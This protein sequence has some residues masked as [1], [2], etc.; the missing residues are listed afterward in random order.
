MK[1]TAMDIGR[2]GGEGPCGWI[3]G[4]GDRR[5][6]LKPL[7]ARS[8]VGP[9]PDPGRNG[10]M[11]QP[12]IFFS[13]DEIK[14]FNVFQIN[15]NGDGI[16]RAVNVP[17]SRCPLV[18]LF[19][20]GALAEGSGIG[21]ARAVELELAWILSSIPLQPRPMRLQSHLDNGHFTTGRCASCYRL[22]WTA[23]GTGV[24]FHLTCFIP[25]RMESA[26][27]VNFNFL[28]Y[29]CRTLLL[30]L[31]NTRHSISGIIHEEPYII[32]PSKTPAT[33]IP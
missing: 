15:N 18:D 4:A 27:A 2:R 33:A 23:I 14:S 5:E 31:L 17:S 29:L 7:F 8:V 16:R 26:P 25:L 6:G 9:R 10:S 28:S 1:R 24:R 19:D 3:A 30:R 22:Q 12:L 21:N 32:H 11:E 13:N 20:D